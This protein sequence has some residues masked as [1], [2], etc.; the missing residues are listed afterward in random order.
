MDS[1]AAGRASFPPTAWS[2]LAGV[3]AGG[4]ARDRALAEVGRRY[5]TP[6]YVYLR[7]KGWKEADAQ[8]LTQ[9][10]FV[11]L[12][13]KALLVRPDPSKGRFRSWLRAV[14]EHFLANEARVRGALK[15]GGGK[16]IVPLD[17]E[18]AERTI[19]AVRGLAA[20]DA[21]DRAWA[22]EVIGRAVRRLSAELEA[23]GK[24]AVVGTLKRR[25]GMPHPDE[26]E[27]TDVQVHR[28]RKRLRAIILEEVGD[29]VKDPDDLAIE[30]S[31]LFRALR[32]PDSR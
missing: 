4:S 25:I 19:R 18:E 29:S 28:A 26:G 11:H 15:K 32:G 8:D 1:S 21:F 13:E 20:P 3:A 2:L 23:A 10:F 12:L 16:R 14:L 24:P 7:R 17:V 27:A 6:V 30:V 22:I 5:W 9:S 31:D